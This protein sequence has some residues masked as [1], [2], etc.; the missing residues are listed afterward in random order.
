[1]F[2]F[3]FQ[4]QVGSEL[5]GYLCLIN[6]PKQSFQELDNLFLLFYKSNHFT[7]VL[8]VQLKNLLHFVEIYS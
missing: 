7:K 8:F 5:M 3:P 1:M 6:R 2:F 4:S